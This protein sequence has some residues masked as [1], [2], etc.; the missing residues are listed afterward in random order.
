MAYE[1]KEWY[2]GETITASKL[3]HIEDGIDTLDK[4]STS[5]ID[6]LTSNLNSEIQTRTTETT[7]LKSRVDQIVAPTGEAPSAAEVTDARVGAD[8]KTYDSVG[9]AIRT[10]VTNLKSALNVRDTYLFAVPDNFTIKLGQYWKTDTSGYAGHSK[11]CRSTKKSADR[12]VT[13]ISITGGVY[14]FQLLAY[15]TEDS[16]PSYY[17][18]YDADLKYIPASARFYTLN[19]KRLDNAEMTESDVESIVDVLS[20]YIST[21]KSLTVDNAPADAA[22]VGEKYDAIN[23]ALSANT[24]YIFDYIGADSNVNRNPFVNYYYL[25]STGERKSSRTFFSLADYIACS[26]GD[27]IKITNRPTPYRK[28][29]VLYWSGNTF[30][31]GKYVETASTDESVLL[32]APDNA[33][34]F[35]V[36]FQFNSEIVAS[37]FEP[38]MVFL[39]PVDTSLLNVYGKGKYLTSGSLSSVTV[40][41]LYSISPENTIDDL[42]DNYATFGV[43]VVLPFK[44]DQVK[45]FFTDSRNR[46]FVRT[47]NKDDHSVIYDWVQYGLNGAVILS[48]GKLSD[49]ILDNVYPISL[50]NTITDM[51]SGFRGGTLLNLKGAF[52]STQHTA[53]ILVDIS[54]K[55]ATRFVYQNGSA[56]AWHYGIEA[57]YLFNNGDLA[58]VIDTESKVKEYTDVITNSADVDSFIFY[59]DPHLMN[60]SRISLLPYYITY[61]QKYYNS[62]PVDFVVCGGDWL[63]TNDI[64][65]DAKYKLGYIDGFCNKMFNNHYMAVGN[66]DYNYLGKIADG[67]TYNGEIPTQTLVNLWYRKYH[68]AYYTFTGTCA[69]FYV[70]DSGVID[71]AEVLEGRYPDTMTTYRWEQVHWFAE[72][73]QESNDSHI[74][75]LMHIYKNGGASGIVTSMSTAIGQ[76]IEAFN[77][78]NRLTIDGASYD[79][80]SATGRIEFILAGHN[81]VDHYGVLGGIPVVVTRWFY[82]DGVPTFDMIHADYTKR[83]L[84]MIRVGTGDNRTFNL[85]TGEIIY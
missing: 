79:F 22:V 6:T 5:K 21:D 42:P 25:A 37:E 47:I 16:N 65:N 13:A 83:R 57:Q 64:I 14:V 69:R 17:T 39:N 27:L 49:Y 48:D 58:G 45:Q 77:S 2:S 52:S 19:F 23:L 38:I 43:L 56:T 35:M 62:A 66:H 72:K 73:L 67:D 36:Q 10:Q 60:S 84:Y 61:L 51:P 75:I 20:A 85:D 18:D 54:G 4:G 82:S 29:Y 34:K 74:A 32:T 41:G 15:D 11:R 3:N 1:K 53:Q 26:G 9:N 78:R 28:M 31:T 8:G 12:Q 7:T 76:V 63:T 80:T 59:T 44:T 30:L 70:F 40:P 68:H 24:D 81:H 71:T 55:L 50:S 33:S 46:M